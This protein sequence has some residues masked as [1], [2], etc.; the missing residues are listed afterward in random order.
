MITRHLN[1]TNKLFGFGLG[2]FTLFVFGILS[3]SNNAAAALDNTN[4]L[5]QL[6][7]GPNDGRIAYVTARLMEEYQY[8]QQPLNEEMSKKFFDGYLDSLDPQ[9]LYFL[10]SDIAEFAVYRT[11]LDTLTVNDRG[12]ADLTPAYQIFE[13]FL[14]RLSERVVYEDKLLKRDHFSFDTHQRILLD[15]SKAPYPKDLAAARQLWRQR[16]LYDYL[17]EVV[18][19]RISSTNSTVIVPLPKSA[20]KEIAD[21]LERHYNW[22]LRLF[23]NW[24]NSDVLEAYLNALT[25]AYDPHSDYLNTSH[26]QDFSIDMSLSLFGIGAEL[27]S[28][29]GYCTIISLVPGGPAAKSKQLKPEDRIIAVAQGK[30]PPVDVVDMELSKIV[31]MI[32]GPKGTEVRLTIIPVDD[33]NSH[34]VVTLTRAEIKLPDQ[35]AKAELVLIPNGQGGTNRLGIIDLPSFYAT[36]DLPGDNGN[37]P[38]KSTTADVTRLIK[39]LEQENVG[40]IILDL[41]GNGGG[42]LEEAVNFTGLFV[43]NG[44]VVLVRTPQGRVLVDKN[45]STSALYRGPLVVLVNRFSASATEIVTGAL[46][47]YGRAL[48]VGDTSTYGKGTVQNLNPLRPFIWSPIETASN[49][50]GTVK[51]TIRKFYRIS[52]ASTQ[53]KGVIPDIILPDTLSY[54]TDI[55][56]SSLPNALPWDTI[57]QVDYTPLDMVQPYLPELRKLSDTRVATNQEFI[58]IRQDIAELQKMQVDKAASLNE[59]EALERAK[60]NAL[61]QKERDAERA[62]RMLPDEQIYEITVENSGK[63]GLPPML[64]PTNMVDTATNAVAKSG[65]PARSIKATRTIPMTTTAAETNAP[66]TDA[67]LDETE[68]ILENYIKLM[69]TNQNHTEVASQLDET[70]QKSDH[71]PGVQKVR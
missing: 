4:A 65:P 48:I 66:P 7:P 42:S 44:P 11:N 32:R 14:E 18:S 6:T 57:P 38:E 59:H 31:Q 33:P 61:R 25:H 35:E 39:K 37:L 24:D 53:L 43:T 29:D 50:P 49:D 3:N 17:Q 13:R 28:E 34:R 63:P 46:Q 26:A 69:D 23:T 22:M 62:K 56:E 70:A 58:Y 15:R 9:H 21:K 5:P 55:G 47:D 27:R 60:N 36:V 12:V 71:L 1:H 45:T 16:L 19:R 51:I 10:Q 20:P 54:L 52:G 30:Q 8:S 41:R 64:W 40:G 67:W 2:I 68:H